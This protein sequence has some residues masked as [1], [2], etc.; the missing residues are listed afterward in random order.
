MFIL[1]ILGVLVITFAIGRVISSYKAGEVSNIKHQVKYLIIWIIAIVAAMIFA[2]Y[3]ILISLNLRYLGII[4]YLFM[5]AV[6]I[7]N[8]V[9][10][11]KGAKKEK[12]IKTNSFMIGGFIVFLVLFGLFG[13]R[14]WL[15]AEEYASLID[16]EE[17]L[18][19]IEDIQTVNVDTLPLVDKSYGYKLGQLKLGEYPG[20]GSE[21]E[22][23]E[24]SDIIYQG[25]QY[26]VAPLE[27]RGFFKWL[28][29]NSVGTPG[30][31]LI[32]KIT[33]ETE[34][35]NLREDSGEGLIYTPSAYLDQD[36][37]RHTYYSGLNR[38]RLENQFFEIDEEGN[39]Y[40]VLQYS[41]PTIFING[42]NKINR[43]AVVNAMTGK[44]DEYLP[45]DEPDWIESVYP[46]GLLFEQLD[47]WGSLQN[48][49]LN[50]VFAQ[51]EVIKPSNGTR[52]IMNGDELFYFTGFTSAG[53]DEST[54]GFLYTGMKSK[55]TKLFRFPGATEEA[56]MNKVVTLLPQ[57]NI[58]T[59][60]PIPLNVEDV[61]TYFI[62]IKGEDGRILRYVYVS[63]QD[64]EIYSMAETETA[65]YNNYL[66]KLSSTNSSSITDITGVMTDIV[67]YVSNGDT[68][69]WIEIDDD[70][71]Y[72][73][74]VSNFTDIEMS[75]F[76]S[77]NIGDTITFRNL[78]YNVIQIVLD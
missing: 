63:V 56:A 28:G 45:G 36:L 8:I 11:Y 29:N 76:T 70:K 15:H 66:V 38:Y 17:D 64:L 4:F 22:A 53:S 50:S 72:K 75:Y 47:Y 57:N 69:Y 40:Y 73:I 20:I 9:Y 39:P 61:P 71:R 1:G 5:L 62:L 46:S 13:G 26:L 43:I 18:D 6:F 19:F 24:Y 37:V 77:L 68:I 31:I 78:E 10:S 67:S 23:G 35:V 16:V 52:V 21:F 54:I 49:W 65:A 7:I 2:N 25:K 60:F 27:Y 12:R 34:F 33:G 44:V 48:G 59:S 51:K 3:Y 42:G 30:Y 55:E 14:P 32:D 41:L 74:N 58:S